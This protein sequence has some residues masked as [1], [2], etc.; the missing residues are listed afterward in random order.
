[1]TRTGVG[2]INGHSGRR[3][4]EL[5]PER[6]F[7]LTLEGGEGVGKTTLM[8]SLQTL[9]A[10][11]HVDAVF[12]R[13]PGGSPRAEALRKVLL[14]LDAEDQPMS[15]ETEALIICAARSDHVRTLIR[16]A[17]AR[18][19]LVVCDRFSDST[20]AYQRDA[21]P[22][23]QLEALIDFAT[24]GLEPDLTILLDGNPDQLLERRKQRS[25]ETDRFEAR[26]LCFHQGVRDAFLKIAGS[27]P[28]RFC[29]IDA[30]GSP[31]QVLRDVLDALEQ[32]SGIRLGAQPGLS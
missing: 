32:K 28:H 29:I 25:A 4:S 23:A 11:S 17:L 22:Q 24:A 20:R 8:R 14:S 2:P 7:F 6:G 26:D 27:N 15:P 30:A 1:M 21:F 9:A 31:E 18:G 3:R 5:N 19:T 13:E 10:D 12:T 16:P